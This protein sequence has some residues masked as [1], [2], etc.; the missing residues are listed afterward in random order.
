MSTTFIDTRGAART[1]PSLSDVLKYLRLPPEEWG[2][3]RRRLVALLI[4]TV[5]FALGARGWIAADL[6]GVDASRA[7]FDSATQRFADARLSLTQ[8]P[9]LR[10]DAA[11]TPAARSSA[12]WNSAD[13]VRVVSGLAAQTGVVLLN[14]EPGPASG[15]GAQSVRPM[16]LTAQTDFVH[17]MAF[18]RGLS[19]LPVLIVP[20]DVTV[21]RSGGTLAVSAA[22]SVFSGLRPAV[23]SD[24]QNTL[25]E[26]NLD[27]DEDEDV[28]FY[29]PFATPPVLAGAN[30]IDAA[31]LRLV[32]LLHDRSHSLALL[33]TP[34]GPAT[35]VAGEQLGAERITRLDAL[36]I[37]LANRVATRTLALAEAS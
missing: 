3:R 9:A 32:G 20:D 18:L 22:L 30:Q 11:I 17:L 4:A 14:V 37:T 28:V 27:M 29:D 24:P 33:E 34:D 6:S 35:V 13:D 25:A 10:R 7:A 23:T 16:H 26:D 1:R 36:G 31:L 5:V 12:A 21:K 2:V 8:L 19:E 15:T